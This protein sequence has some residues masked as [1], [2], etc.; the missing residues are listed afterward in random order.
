M[1]LLD[2]FKKDKRPNEKTSLQITCPACQ[3]STKYYR[4]AQYPRDAEVDEYIKND[5]D[6]VMP[7]QW[8]ERLYQEWI[9][10]LT[11][12]QKE[13]KMLIEPLLCHIAA[14]SELC[15]YSDN[16]VVLLNYY[17]FRHEEKTAGLTFR[18]IKV[19]P[20]RSL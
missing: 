4:L 2:K 10:V 16:D 9:K 15:R 1:G 8:N 14:H 20:Q 12:E 3:K 7:L 11:P 6:L 19:F 18:I 5:D 13:Q 17:M